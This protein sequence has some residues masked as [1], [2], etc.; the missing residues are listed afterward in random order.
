MFVDTVE[1]N[2]PAEKGGLKPEDIVTSIN[3][4]PVKKGQDLIDA[5]ADSHVG[6]TLQ[7]GVIRDKKPMTLSVVVGDRTKIFA[8]QYGGGKSTGSEG[9]A[10][11]LQMKF[12]MTVQPLRSEDRQQLGFKG[13]GGAV[14][15]SVDTGSFADDIG[16]AKGDII[17]ELNRQPVN[18]PED[19]RKIQSTLKPG[20]AVAFHVMRQAAGP[21]GGGDWQS[22]FLAGRV[23]E[24][25]Q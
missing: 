19:I 10:E 15:A 12:G 17:V 11:G 22:L 9:P 1:P 16:L 4:K 18:S 5:V 13:N 23:P 2:G 21:R 20:D 6:S 7:L 3:G 24:G 14:I 8:D 25:N